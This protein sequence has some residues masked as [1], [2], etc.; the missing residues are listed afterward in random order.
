[1]FPIYKWHNNS[2][3]RVNKAE[4]HKVLTEL[5]KTCINVQMRCCTNDSL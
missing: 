3:S 4:E 5:S 2:I 1:M